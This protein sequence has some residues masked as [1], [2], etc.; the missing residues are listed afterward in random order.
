QPLGPY[1]VSADALVASES[2]GATSGTI[3]AGR[4]TA[5][6]VAPNCAVKGCA[7]FIGAAGGGVWAAN[8]AL[9]PQPNW[10]AS[11]NGIPSNAIG[12]LAFDPN[13]PNAKTIY[14][15]TGEPNGS[16]DS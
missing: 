12:S 6:A 8:N 13:D 14:A 7:M 9:D 15:G 16:G 2:T 1:G 3:Y 5:I 10:H 11:S 4:T